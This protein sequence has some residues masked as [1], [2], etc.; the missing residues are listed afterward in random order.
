MGTSD[1]IEKVESLFP[2]LKEMLD[3]VENTN[4]DNL[5]ENYIIFC[6]KHNI[7]SN[8]IQD[9]YECGD[10]VNNENIKLNAVGLD[11]A[12][13]RLRIK[14]GTI[15]PHMGKGFKEYGYPIEDYKKYVDFVLDNREAIIS[16][17]KSQI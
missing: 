10:S 5:D 17:I 4:L 11:D 3:L 2:I 6:Q 9:I 7:Y 13:N 1:L 14:I 8:V 16:Y 15:S 12:T